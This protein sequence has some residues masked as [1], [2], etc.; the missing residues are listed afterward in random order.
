MKNDKWLR[1]YLQQ[2][3]QNKFINA[4]NYNKYIYFTVNQF[5]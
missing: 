3:T 1:K 5:K 4:T 2:Q